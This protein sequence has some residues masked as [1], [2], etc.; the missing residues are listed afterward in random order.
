MDRTIKRK[1]VRLRY[2]VDDEIQNTIKNLD[3]DDNIVDIKMDKYY[4]YFKC[5][6]LFK[7]C[8]LIKKKEIIDKFLNRMLATIQCSMNDIEEE[9]KNSKY[10]KINIMELERYQNKEGIK[11]MVD[12]LSLLYM[13][14]LMNELCLEKE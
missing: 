11:I 12:T 3:I 2:K 10:S 1:F 8:I 4:Y 7:L 14:D 5:L 9:I 6:N 13:D